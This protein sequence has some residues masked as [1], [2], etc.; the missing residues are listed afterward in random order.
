MIDG[1][2]ALELCFYYFTDATTSEEVEVEYTFGYF[3]D[4]SGK[5]RIMLHHSSVP[6]M[7]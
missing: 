6:Y 7:E 2:S 5:I 1:D 3:K 4:E